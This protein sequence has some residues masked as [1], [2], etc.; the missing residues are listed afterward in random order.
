MM[1]KSEIEKGELRPEML[2]TPYQRF[3]YKVFRR[4]ADKHAKNLALQ[5]DLQKAHMTIRP[6]EYVAQVWMTAL[7]GLIMS[8]ILIAIF[9]LINSIKPLPFIVMLIIYISPLYLGFGTYILF[10]YAPA[11]VAKERA[12]QIDR[13]LH[14]AIN[15]IAT[16][17]SAD[18]NL[19]TILRELAKEG[20][21]GEIQKEALWIVR[22]IDVFNQ[23]IITA[24]R[25][26]IERSPSVLFQDF[27]QGIITT[28]TSGG[29]LKP[30]F[31]MKA[32][33][34]MR[35]YGM[36]QKKFHEALAMLAES[37]IIVVVAFPLFLI[38]MM[39]L[40]VF[41]GGNPKATMQFFYIVIFFLIPLSQVGFIYAIMRITPEV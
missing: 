21:Y 1:E 18:V 8:F 27:L 14:Y 32:K 3:S 11:S 30:Y 4:F 10:L 5:T 22:D 17:A 41:V 29:E 13:K 37:F 20:V 33:E 25:N 31:T 40:M 28:I 36:E 16:L 15:F 23:D 19:A 6:E 34:Y 35:Y 26:A 12:R 2:L 39:S 24:L 9:T 38:V 7:I